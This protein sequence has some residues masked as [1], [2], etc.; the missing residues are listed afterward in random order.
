MNNE[1]KFVR[2]EASKIVECMRDAQD[3]DA[4]QFDIKVKEL[5]RNA[6][7]R[8]RRIKIDPIRNAHKSMMTSMRQMLV[9]HYLNYTV[10]VDE[11]DDKYSRWYLRQGRLA[12]QFSDGKVY[13]SKVGLR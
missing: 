8:I 13:I 9:E 12:S 1:F 7:K 4:K 10:R 11:R 6:R 2:P 3:R 5:P